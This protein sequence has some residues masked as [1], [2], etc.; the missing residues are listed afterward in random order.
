MHDGRK[1]G[2]MV[3][4]HSIAHRN[5]T[6]RLASLDAIVSNLVE[7]CIARCDFQRF[8]SRNASR[9][10]MREGKTSGHTFAL[11]VV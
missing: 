2:A 9:D 6:W 11:R 1:R 4:W 3:E 5:L 8:S 10:A 7:H